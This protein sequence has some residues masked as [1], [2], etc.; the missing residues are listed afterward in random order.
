MAQIQL[1]LA[2]GSNIDLTVGQNRGRT[3]VRKDGGREVYLIA[4]ATFEA[5]LAG[6]IRLRDRELLS[7]ERS[8]V[9]RMTLV[10]SGLTSILEQDPADSSWD[11]VQPLNVDV[12]LRTAM[13]TAIALGGLR[14][15]RMADVSPEIAGFPSET[16][17]EIQFL[18]GRTE[19]LEVGANVPDSELVYV[20]RGALPDRIAELPRREL[21]ALKKAWAR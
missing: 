20:R 8:Q 6:P 1:A 21:S 18:D 2:D 7:F 13:Q 15:E 3:Y 9:R 16:K 12:D 17:I 10:E 11:V 5:L 19:S 4:N 14:A